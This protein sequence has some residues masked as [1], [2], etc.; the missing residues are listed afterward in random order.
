MEKVARC[1]IIGASPDTDVDFIRRTVSPADYVIC[2][3]GGLRFAQA[4]GLPIRMVVGDFDS[5]SV[6]AD[7]RVVRYPIEKDFT[8]LELA[9][10][11]GIE[12][13]FNDFLI[14]GGT[15]GRFTHTLANVMLLFRYALRGISVAL[16]DG[17]TRS[18]VLTAPESVMRIPPS[19]TYS[20]FSVGGDSVISEIGAKY[21][22]D[23]HVLTG[24]DSLGVSNFSC[25]G[26]SV[27]LHQGNIL[28][29]IEKN[30]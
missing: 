23:H 9:V 16:E 29:V 2:A 21:P 17:D 7:I 18:Q 14:L 8:D 20:V 24:F 1:V 12:A 19:V 15:G 26:A 13:G 6:P 11:K 3:D 10:E 4:A 30:V 25:D 27:V 28:I 5:G 22:L